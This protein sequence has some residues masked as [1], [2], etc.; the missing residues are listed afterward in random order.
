MLKHVCKILTFLLLVASLNISGISSDEREKESTI[1]KLRYI[2]NTLEEQRSNLDKYGID[3]INTYLQLLTAE[4]ENAD[5]KRLV[6]LYDTLYEKAQLEQLFNKRSVL[7]DF[8]MVDYLSFPLRIAGCARDSTS[9]T[10]EEKVQIVERQL[11]RTPDWR[12]MEIR[13]RQIQEYESYPAAIEYTIREIEAGHERL[14]PLLFDFRFEYQ[15]ILIH[16]EMARRNIEI[17]NPHIIPLEQIQTAAMEMR[18]LLNQDPTIGLMRLN[19]LGQQFDQ[20][21]EYES[22][23]QYFQSLLEKFSLKENTKDPLTKSILTNLQQLRHHQKQ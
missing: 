11:Q 21:E 18:A 15:N 17:W 3:T 22:G 12:I 7:F 4:Y 2:E 16:Q 8:F 23:I 1:K 9:L 5:D 13:A 14:W 20:Y 19:V 6:N 10:K